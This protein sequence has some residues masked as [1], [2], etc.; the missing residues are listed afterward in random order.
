MSG[1]V[2][3]AGGPAEEQ[4]GRFQVFEPK[5]FEPKVFARRAAGWDV[6]ARRV[7]GWDVPRD[8]VG[9]ALRAAAAGAHHGVV[10]DAVEG[11]LPGVVADAVAGELQGAAVGAH[12]GVVADAAGGALLGAAV[13]VPAVE[14][15][16]LPLVAALVSLQGAEFSIRSSDYAYREY[17]H[18]RH[19]QVVCGCRAYHFVHERQE[20]SRQEPER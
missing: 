18:L 8:E 3:K 4:D 5:V 15:G 9:G 11:A 2:M 20:Q 1:V 6:P 7:A 10:A 16:A 13:D 19:Q 12:H 14:L 17:L